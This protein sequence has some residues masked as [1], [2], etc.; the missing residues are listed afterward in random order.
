MEKQLKEYIKAIIKEYTKDIVFRHNS[1]W[2][3][4]GFLIGISIGYSYGYT[5]GLSNKEETS[6]N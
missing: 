2:F 1:M 4:G 6:I 5:S 3:I